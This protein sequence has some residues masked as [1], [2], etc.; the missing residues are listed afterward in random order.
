MNKKIIKIKKRLWLSTITI[1]CTL[2]GCLHRKSFV[3]S[4]GLPSWPR[5][6]RTGRTGRL[7]SK[8]L[9]PRDSAQAS[10]RTGTKKPVP[11]EKHTITVWIHGTRFESNF[12]RNKIFKNI[13]YRAFI[14]NGLLH[15][16]AYKTGSNFKKIAQ[17]LAKQNTKRFT[18][19]NFYIFG[20]SGKLNHKKRMSSALQLHISLLQ[21]INKYK[22]KHNVTPKIRF[23]THS[24]GGNVALCF[25]KIN[26]N[27]KDKIIISE[28]VLLAC[29]VQEKTAPLIKSKTFESIYCLYSSLDMI[30]VIDP[31]GLHD[32]KDKKRT[33]KPFFSER[34]F[35]AHNNLSQVKL[36]VNG[37]GILHIEFILSR[38]SKLLPHILQEIDTWKQEENNYNLLKIR[39]NNSARKMGFSRKTLKS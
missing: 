34:L 23:V 6:R 11:K 38:F 15:H 18:L 25:A 1:L 17:N 28:L 16:S 14:Q 39:T 36:K 9:I 21:L 31:Q 7:P 32:I 33:K 35:P 24:H 3:P 8:P 29:P 12:M 13:A 5:L 2:T 27:S 30:Q 26:D 37:R 20:W 22:K 19:E 10:L 4:T